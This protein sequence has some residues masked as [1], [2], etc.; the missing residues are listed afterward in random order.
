MFTKETAHPPLSA[1]KGKL[2]KINKLKLMWNSRQQQLHQEG[3]TER[4]A[5]LIQKDSFKHKL[6]RNLK[7]LDGP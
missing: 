3:V 1:Y 4:A 7:E 2:A 6:L 5:Q